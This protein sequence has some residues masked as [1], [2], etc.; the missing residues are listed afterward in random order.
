[1]RLEV[2]DRRVENDDFADARGLNF[3]VAAERPNAG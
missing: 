2:G 3:R 1:M